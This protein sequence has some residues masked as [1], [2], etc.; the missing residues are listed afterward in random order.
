MQTSEFD[1]KKKKIKSLSLHLPLDKNQIPSLCLPRKDSFLYS[2][3]E[4]KGS[5]S[6]EA[7]GTKKKKEV[8]FTKL[9]PH[10]VFK[11]KATIFFVSHSLRFELSFFSIFR[12]LG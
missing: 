5:F 9:K 12:K 8:S 4:I 1:I 7:G 6:I 3:Q 10:L 2:Q 11:P